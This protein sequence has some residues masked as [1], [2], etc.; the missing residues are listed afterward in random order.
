MKKSYY[1]LGLILILTLATRLILAFQT[2]YFTG[3]DSYFSLRQIENIKSTG[4]PLYHDS[5]SYGGRDQ[6][7]MPFFYYLLAFFDLFMP[8]GLVGKII[9][10]VLVSLMVVIVYF[11]SKEISNDE[12]ASLFSAF[13][14]GFIPIFFKETVN[15]ISVYALVFPLMLLLIYLFLRITDKNMAYYF[16]IALF[17]SVLTSPAVIL[18]LLGFVFYILLIK[19]E[20]LKQSRIEAEV[21]LFSIVLTTWLMFIVFKKAFLLNGL[22]V[23]WQN[24]PI[25][26][27]NGYFS[28]II[29]F[30]VIYQIGSLPLSYGVYSIYDNLFRKKERKLYLILGLSFSTAILLWM[31]L[32]A[33]GPGLMCL[34]LM[35]TLL[36]PQFYNFTFSYIKKTRFARLRGAYFATL[37]IAFIFASVIP[38]IASGIS[39]EKNAVSQKEMDALN[40][41]KGHTSNDSVILSMVDEGELISSIAGRANVADMHFMLQ[42]DAEKRFRDIEKVYMSRFETEALGVL[43]EYDVDYIYFSGAARKAFGIDDLDYTND[44]RC[45]EMR[46]NDEV[47]IFKVTCELK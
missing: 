17:I 46:Y 45:F 37:L 7:F 36:F 29:I 26:I 39:A 34:G 15:T 18:L 3:D 2:P 19:I 8:L 16:L 11:I 31:K 41:I 5:L 10:N 9:P 14:S 13:I 25:Q 24:I 33:L 28:D 21:I 38:S 27:L 22:S 1:I 30:G 40:W 35:M 6:V 44:S 23:V 4:V 42:K 20:S 32:I 12:D 47:S 43:Q